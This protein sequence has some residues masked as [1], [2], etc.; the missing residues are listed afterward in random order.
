M[1]CV[2]IKFKKLAFGITTESIIQIDLVVN[3]LEPH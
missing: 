1:T 3:T 2:E